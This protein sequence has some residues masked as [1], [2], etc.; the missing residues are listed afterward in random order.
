MRFAKCVSGKTMEDDHDADDIRGGPNGSLSL[1]QARQN[2]K[3]FRACD[4]RALPHVRPPVPE[5]L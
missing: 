3:S 4:E 1:T 2:F 5:E